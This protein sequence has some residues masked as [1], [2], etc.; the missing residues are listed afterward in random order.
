MSS[1]LEFGDTKKLSN[2]FQEYVQD[3]FVKT[4]RAEESILHSLGLRGTQ[5]D[6]VGVFVDLLM[7]QVVELHGVG[8][9]KAAM[10]AAQ[11]ILAFG[12]WLGQ[13]GNAKQV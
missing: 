3:T 11:T 6:D 13:T 8:N 7:H 2:E 10:T 5:L 12:V 9:E 4:G 1:T